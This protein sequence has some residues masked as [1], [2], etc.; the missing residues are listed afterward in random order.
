MNKEIRFIISH[1][2]NNWE[3][4]HVFGT[5]LI[6][7]SWK[8]SMRGAQIFLFGIFTNM[9]NW[10]SWAAKINE[11]KDWS[12]CVLLFSKSYRKHYLRTRLHYIFDVIDMLNSKSPCKVRR[13]YVWKN[14]IRFIKYSYQYINCGTNPRKTQN[15]FRQRKWLEFELLK[16]AKIFTCRCVSNTTGTVKF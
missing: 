6:G 15:I 3:V 8:C 10:P 9:F 14:I 16:F 12:A 2:C 7:M 5:D 13:K 4:D 11:G 1:V